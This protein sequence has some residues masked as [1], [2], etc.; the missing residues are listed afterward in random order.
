MQQTKYFVPMSGIF[1]T[2]HPLG[3]QPILQ[4]F[5]T[6]ELQQTNITFTSSCP[7]FANERMNGWRMA[8]DYQRKPSEHLPPMLDDNIIPILYV[9]SRRTRQTWNG[10]LLLLKETNPP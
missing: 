3:T 9:A 6:Q 4:H 1:K 8:W 7:W 5:E 10:S 2:T